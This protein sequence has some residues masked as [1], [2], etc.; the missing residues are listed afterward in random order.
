MMLSDLSIKKPVF[1]W[2]VMGSLLL[3]GYIGFSRLGVSQNPD[4]DSPVVNIRLTW[5][6][7]SP[8]V[9]ENEVIDPIEEVMMTVEGIKKVTSTSRFG[10][11][12]ITAE[13]SLEKDIDVAVQEVQSKLAQAQRNL[14]ADMDPAVIQKVNPEDQP[15][16]WIGVAGTRP[17]KEI[18]SYVQ[19]HLLDEFQTVPGVGEITL[20]G[21]TEPNLRVW[22]KPEK[23]TELEITVD[24]VITA[25]A[26]QHSELPGGVLQAER[27]EYNVRILGEA[28]SI[29]E[30]GNITIPQRVGQGILWRTLRIEDIADIEEGLADVRRISRV[31][32]EPSISL[33]IRKQ[34]GANAVE[35][36]HGIKEKI[37]E[38]QKTLPEG[39]TTSLNFDTTKF[40]ED[41]IHELIVTLLLA[42]LFT[43]V[44]CWLF[45]G[46]IS[47]TV[48]VLFAIPTALGGTFMVIYFLGFTLNTITLMAISLVIGIVVDD[49]IV[50]LENIVRR[51]EKGESQI[52]AAVY[53]SRE[54]FFSVVVISSAVIAIFLPVAFM[55][56]LIGKFF[57]EFGIT[58]SVAVAFSLLEAVTLAP[59]R[60]SQFLST[61][62]ETRIGK[63]VDRWMKKV[64]GLY[65]NSLQGALKHRW[66]VL[67]A[68]TAIFLVSLFISSCLRREMTPTQDQGTFVV[69]F[70]TPP[71]SSL[72][73]TDEA[74]KKAEAIV[75]QRPELAKF[76][77]SVGGGSGEVNSGNIFITMKEYKERPRSKKTG[78]PVSQEEFMQEIRKSLKDIPGMY[79][80]GIQDRSQTISVGAGRG[81]PIEISIQ[82]P[83]WDKLGEYSE[84][85]RERLSASGLAV[86]AD[87][88]YRVGVPEVRIIPDREKAAA[89][90]VTVAAIA[91]TINST[92]GGVRTGKYTKGGR[93]YD[94]RV[95]LRDENRSGSADLSKLWVRNIRGEMV[96]LSDV[97]RVIEKPTLLQI[98]RENRDRSVTVT[99]NVAP[100]KSQAKAIEEAFR[101]AKEVLPDG[102]RAVATGSSEQF[103]DVFR[104]LS[105]ALFLGIAIAY[106]ILAAQF[107]SFLHPFI[108]LLALPFSLSGAL[109]AL[110]LTNHSLNMMSFIG[111]LLL[112]GIVKKNAIL[113]VEFT[114]ARRAAGLA[115][116][117]ALLEACP[118]RLRPILMTSFAIVA[119][120]LPSAMVLGPGA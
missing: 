77:G 115:T 109:A 15:I 43:A 80:V 55:K 44:V 111:I 118:L 71:G 20:G 62:H 84:A 61:G 79:R 85:I 72:A 14:P 53:G 95:S 3:F 101:I 90:G 38:L 17:R 32:G 59:M 26:A 25:I 108:I 70:Q 73:F 104:E 7:A 4:V 110:W 78:K 68:A 120:A 31:N 19:D 105:F 65:A 5:E 37:K 28:T 49:A 93:R 91:R 97:T 40:I 60:C 98:Q 45:L 29:E 52:E 106:M 8:E 41:N 82:G 33:G 10:A 35:V 11:G 57:F 18:A 58:I 12:S 76:F 92:V 16:L 42:I 1:A 88:N 89:R 116:D 87:T 2:M 74:F 39:I 64:T 113:L 103:R 23:M 27:E 36:A 13:F 114:N 75:S 117:P 63:V 46:S 94:I 9:M 47:S 30:F 34:R 66:K 119:G 100:K 81:Y 6:G 112:M 99:A 67:I 107:N 22:L 21:F 50:V 69:R 83:D 51:R 48:N 54:I 24:D 96:P 86:D 102:Y 56:G